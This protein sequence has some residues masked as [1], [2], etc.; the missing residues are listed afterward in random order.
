[1]NLFGDKKIEIVKEEEQPKFSSNLEPRTMNLEMAKTQEQPRHILPP[2]IK[3]FKVEP[4]LVFGTTVKDEKMEQAKMQEQPRHILPPPIKEIKVEPELISGTM[5]KDEIEYGVP[6][7]FGEILQQVE[8]SVE[9]PEVIGYESPNLFVEEKIEMAKMQEQPKH[10]MPP[11]IK[12]IKT[13]PELVAGTTVKDEKMEMVKTQEQPETTDYGSPNLFGDKKIE[14]VKEE[15]QPKFSSNLEPRTMNLEMAKTQEQPRHILPPPIKEFKVEPEL[16]FGTTVKD[17]KMEQAKMQE[18]PRH[19]LPPPIKEIKVEPELISG[20]MVKDEIEYGVPNLFGEI[21]QQVEASV[22][23]PEVIGYESPNLFVEEKI[24][25][26]KMQEQPKHIMPPPIKEIKT[27]PELVA[28]T[29]VKDEKMEMAKT[30]E[31]PETTDYGSPN[32]FGDKK[33]EI[34]KEQ[35]QPRLFPNPESRIPNPEMAKTQEQPK[36]SSNLEPRTMNLEMAKAQEQ[37]KHIMPPPIKEMKAEPELAAVTTVKDEKI[38]MVKTQEQ[39]KHIMPPPIKEIKA[40]SE[41]I[42]WTTVKDEKIEMAKTQKQPETTD[43]GSPNLFGDKK[44]EIVKEE[45]QP[46]LF[47]NSKFRI[48]NPEMAKTQE[49]PRFFQN[50]EFQIPNPEMKEILYAFIEEASLQLKKGKSEIHIQLKPEHFGKL[51]LRV[52]KQDDKITAKFVVENIEL[53]KLIESDLDSLKQALLEKGIVL[54][55]IEIYVGKEPEK[56][57]EKR[58]QMYADNIK[59]LSSHTRQGYKKEEVDTDEILVNLNPNGNKLFWFISRID[60]IA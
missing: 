60:L 24:E 50:S 7:L 1:P 38:E 4:E 16:V 13:E 11:P 17:E 49:Q 42:V 54:E 48:P 23:A 56:N 45:E 58:H 14:I 34:V 3:E 35:E 57:L 31:Q 33:I 30:Q 53:K 5:V 12:E 25:M 55:G 32:L 37:P 46:R 36:F 41:L 29:T 8:A 22:E 26:A 6:N 20:T 47:P 9:A 2:P 44:I 18:Q 10:I 19:I 43:Y 52:I 40:E 21:L 28:G 51:E 39:P 59:I 27:E 15:E